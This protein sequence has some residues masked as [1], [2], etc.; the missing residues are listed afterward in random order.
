MPPGSVYGGQGQQQQQHPQHPQYHSQHT[1]HPQHPH[2]QHPQYQQPVQQNL[3]PQYGEA[4]YANGN[5]QYHHVQYSQPTYQQQQPAPAPAP[6]PAPT[7]FYPLTAPQ[8]SNYNGAYNRPPPSAAPPVQFVDPSF[9]QRPVAPNQTAY[10]PPIQTSQPAP[11]PAP[12]PAVNVAPTRAPLP[13]QQ[14]S[15]AT[16]SPRLASSQGGSGRPTS[17]DARR[18]PSAGSVAKSPV[19]SHAHVETLPVLIH[20]A[21]DCFSK[22]N[23]GGQ[24]IVRSM[25]PEEVA[26]HHKLVATGLGCLEVAMKSNKLFPRLEAR[27]C[28]RYAGILVDETTNIMEAETAL[29]RGIAVC[30]KHRF[31]DLKYSSQFLLMKTLFQ[32]SQ[33]A[34][35]KSIDAYIADCTTYKHIHWIYAFRFLKAAFHLQSGTSSDHHAL[36]NLRKIAGIATQRDDKAIFVMAMILEGLAHLSSKKDDWVTRVQACIAGAAKLQLNDDVHIPQMD[37]LLLLLDIACSLHQKSPKILKQKMDSL[38]ARLEELRHSP[39]WATLSDEVMLPIHRMANAPSTISNDTRQILRPGEGNVD[40]LVLSTLGKQEAYA[41]AFVMNGI[42]ALSTSTTLGR[43]TQIWNEAARLL[44]EKKPPST[45]RSLPESLRQAG[46]ANEVVYYTY[47]LVGLQAATL[48]DWVRVKNILEVLKNAQPSAGFPKIMTLYLN[49]VLMQGTAQLAAA[50]EIW[51]DPLFHLDQNSGHKTST[52]H[53]EYQLSI[54]AGLNRL[55]ILN[56]NRDEA[57]MIDL[58][59]QLRPLCEDDPDPEIKTAYNLVLSSIDFKP[60]RSMPLQQVKGHI[61][62]ALANAQATQNFHCLSIALNIMR[63]RLFENVAGEQAVKS[64]KAGTAQAK[65]SG[66]ILW[67]SVGE[68]MLGQSYELMGAM[69]EAAASR[70]AGVMFANEAYSRMQALR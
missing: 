12:T 42:V 44:E 29:T 58:I 39:E 24:N 36:E 27:L 47:M 33:K 16:S 62:Q 52:N 38:Q 19:M 25:T 10:T 6:A 40:Y 64:A 21:E 13:P 23:A 28:L 54:L 63:L 60:P 8:F 45:S 50:A 37:V 20:V 70:E 14:V 31:V 57:G 69:A 41:L 3:H 48:C 34:A 66:N 53:I 4:P 68:G 1:Q 65:K 49:G 59:D 56:G 9:L 55:W 2:S 17:K 7:N 46:W 51:S 11:A 30:E 5:P 61:Q 22:A 67:M 32:R 15:S 26:E 35:F 43:S 18:L